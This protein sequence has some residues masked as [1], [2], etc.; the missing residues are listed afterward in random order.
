MVRSIHRTAGVVALCAG[1]AAAAQPITAYWL[2]PVNGQWNDASN[3]STAPYFPSNGQNFGSLFNAVIDAAGSPYTVTMGANGLNPFALQSLDVNSSDATLRVGRLNLAEASF[4]SAGR[5]WLVGEICG[6]GDLSI[7]GVL[8]WD[9]GEMCGN[10]V[11]TIEAGGAALLQ[12][13]STRYLERAFVN[14]GALT[15]SSGRMIVGSLGALTNNGTMTVGITN[16]LE[17]AGAFVNN[18]ALNINNSLVVSVEQFGSTGHIQLGGNSNVRFASGVSLDGSMHIG[19]NVILRIDSSS[20]YSADSSI[21]GAG[22]IDIMGG[23]HVF[24]KG[25]LKTSGE[26][27]VRGGDVTFHEATSG[28]LFLNGGTVRYEYRPDF[29]SSLNTWSSLVFN[30]GFDLAPDA[31]VG[32]GTLAHVDLAQGDRSFR[33]LSLNGHLAMDGD[34]SVLEEFAWLGGSL[35]GPGSTTLSTGAAMTLGGGAKTLSRDLIHTGDIT[36]SGGDLLLDGVSFTSHGQM[37]ATGVGSVIDSSGGQSFINN[38][39]ID[40]GGDFGVLGAFGNNGQVHIQQSATLRIGGPVTLGGGAAITGPGAV[41]FVGGSHTLSDALLATTGAI[42]VSGGSVD[43]DP[44]FDP[45]SWTF[46]GGAAQFLGDKLLSDATL[47]GGELGSTGRLDFQ[48][49]TW[50]GGALVGAGESTVMEG[51]TLALTGGGSRTLSRA[52]VNKGTIVVEGGSLQ[53]NGGGIDNRGDLSLVA[54]ATIGSGANGGTLLNSGQIMSSGAGVIAI[55]GPGLQLVNTGGMH[56]GPGVTL[57]L[58]ANIAPGDLGSLTVDGDLHFTGASIAMSVSGWSVSGGISMLGG[59][60]VFAGSPNPASWTFI[61]GS[62]TFQQEF[63]A[64]ALLRTDGTALRFEQGIMFDPGATAH[65]QNGGS[66]DVASNVAEVARLQFFGGEIAG[67]GDVSV[68]QQLNWRSGVMRGSGRTVVEAGAFGSLGFLAPITLSRTLENFGSV[69][70]ITGVLIVDGGELRNHGLLRPFSG[71]VAQGMGA[72]G[73]I[74]NEGVIR[75]DGSGPFS[76]TQNGASIDLINHGMIEVLEGGMLMLAGSQAL[77]NEGRYL[78]ERSSL[79]A[80]EGDFT[81]TSTAEL[82]FTVG[83]AKDRGLSGLMTIT[84]DAALSGALVISTP[85]T[86]VG[87]WGERWTVLTFA[88]LTSDFDTFDLP[89]TTDETLRWYAQTDG[90]TYDVGVSHIADIDHHGLIGFADLNVIVSSFNAFGSWSDGDVDGDGFVG[91]SDL[92][93]VVSLFNTAAP[94]NVPAPGAALMIGLGVMATRRDRRS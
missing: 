47:S 39:D 30:D 72:G 40:I 67:E 90:E 38:G 86:F 78:V 8:Q 83:G 80:V 76:L 5:L 61:S 85:E 18:G 59:D 77:E 64:G 49:T 51:A 17:G 68:G 7:A 27:W 87:A 1:A 35:S 69:N 65:V 9:S 73:S 28:P 63:D 88:S 82:A 20:T 14:D 91:F 36:W 71:S 60:V 58:G 66:I 48:N 29:G 10:G 4:V 37:S 46:S 13:S 62:A 52:L 11:T 6:E 94:R 93:L 23:E 16:G 43:I 22:R 31:D 25:V 19:S 79:V 3:W 42:R 92:N 89:E 70:L 57:L 12:T 45:T 54:G 84:G 81:N 24:Q 33:T 32:I 44:T 55:E 50:S 74:V 26:F 41:D 34:A 15:W 21:D 56:F 53:L 2:N 75:L